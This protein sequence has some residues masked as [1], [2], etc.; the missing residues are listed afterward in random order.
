[1][2]QRYILPIIGHMKSCKNSLWKLARICYLL[3]N[4]CMPCLSRKVM[5]ISLSIG[6][7]FHPP[8]LIAIFRPFLVIFLTTTFISFTK[9]KFRPSFWGAEQVQIIISSKVM[10]QNANE[11]VTT[12][13]RSSQ[14]LSS[15]VS[16]SIIF[17]WSKIHIF[18]SRS[19]SDRQQVV[20]SYP[21]VYPSPIRVMG[22]LI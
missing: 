4:L 15:Y 6:N 3:N 18:L 14:L 10:T 11:A 12:R 21:K 19:G 2:G 22:T 16:L 1:M 8:S 13:R 9:L 20:A 7:R 5:Q 17:T